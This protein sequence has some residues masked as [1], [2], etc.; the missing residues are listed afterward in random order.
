MDAFDEMNKKII[1]AFN[2]IVRTEAKVIITEEFKDITN[3][4]MHILAAVGLGEGNNMST[5]A[6]ALGITVGSLTTSMNSLVKKGYVVR[7]RSEK[8]RRVVNIC[9][10]EKG[11][12]AYVHHDNFHHEMMRYFMN[13]ITEEELGIIDKLIANLNEFLENY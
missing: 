8:D 2:E 6:K 9:L 13:G 10:T 3:N 7:N 5:I 11:E 12:A 4:D 1:V